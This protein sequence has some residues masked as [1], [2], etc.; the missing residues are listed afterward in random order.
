M[1]WLAAS[2]KAQAGEQRDQGVQSNQ[3]KAGRLAAAAKSQLEPAT[4]CV[5]G[6]RSNQREPG[7]LQERT[8]RGVPEDAEEC[9][10][11]PAP[12]E[13]HLRGRGRAA[14]PEN[15]SRKNRQTSAVSLVQK[16]GRKTLVI[17]STTSRTPTATATSTPGTRTET[18]SG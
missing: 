10:S 16:S 14:P 3:R 5:T 4:S 2:T 11:I 12:Q 18:E 1:A 6:R 17:L 9:S 8:A 15:W 13:Q 7:D